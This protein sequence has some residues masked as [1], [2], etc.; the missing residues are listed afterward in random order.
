[1]A[2]SNIVFDGAGSGIGATRGAPG[3][4]ARVGGGGA[5]G[6]GAGA[7]AGGA[8][9]AAAALASA[10]HFIASTSVTASRGGGVGG[11]GA[12][13]AG[14]A[15]PPT[16]IPAQ[17]LE[18]AAGKERIRS[19]ARLFDPDAEMEEGAV[20]VSVFVFAY[21]LACSPPG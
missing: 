4:A 13:A 17:L 3:S 14:A 10:Q 8:T 11:A 1:M 7:G 9:Q 15:M 2:S 21:S 18:R 16:S 6:G 5:G 19:V 20:E 12:G